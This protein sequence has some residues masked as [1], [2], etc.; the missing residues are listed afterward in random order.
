MNFSGKMIFK[1]SRGCIVG[2]SIVLVSFRIWQS[3]WLQIL[4]AFFVGILSG[5]FATTISGTVEIFKK[6][7]KRSV[8]EMKGIKK[9]FGEITEAFP[10]FFSGFLRALKKIKLKDTILFFAWTFHGIEFLGKGLKKLLFFP[11]LAITFIFNVASGTLEAII[12]LIKEGF[13]KTLSISVRIILLLFIVSPL[14]IM[15]VY[16]LIP[17][18]ELSLFCRAVVEDGFLMLLICFHGYFLLFSMIYILFKRYGDELPEVL[19][20]KIWGTSEAPQLWEEVEKVGW[21]KAESSIIKCNIYYAKRVFLDICPALIEALIIVTVF[22]VVA[23]IVTTLYLIRE[24]FDLRWS[25]FV[26]LGVIF[27]GTVGLIH[28]HYFN[29]TLFHVFIYGIMSG[30][31]FMLSS[32]Y[33]RVFNWEKTES[34]L[35]WLF[36]GN[37]ENIALNHLSHVFMGR[38]EKIYEKRMLAW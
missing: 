22:T 25:I 31:I 27:G 10:R 29:E 4:F 36:N 19:C 34:V 21:L 11:F 9:E 2:I 33:L 32:I 15:H 16:G 3:D 1:M 20:L 18:S 28:D 5:L 26:S 12:N 17:I 13:Y 37:G 7:F 35:Y 30:L 23:I 38:V 24:I 6:A 14:I 8:R